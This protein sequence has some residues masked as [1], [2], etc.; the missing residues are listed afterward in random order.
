[1]NNDILASAPSNCTGSVPVDAVQLPSAEPT[2][3]QLEQQLRS[4][5]NNLNEAAWDEQCLAALEYWFTPSLRSSTEQQHQTLWDQYFDALAVTVGSRAAL[6][7][8]EDCLRF[9]LIE[10]I[11]ER[12]KCSAS[13]DQPQKQKRQL[14]KRGKDRQQRSTNPKAWINDIA[15]IGFKGVQLQIALHIIGLC[16]KA[17]DQ[18]KGGCGI[19]RKRV[20]ERYQRSLRTVEV[21]IQKAAGCRCHHCGTG[22]AS[23]EAEIRRAIR[24][25]RQNQPHRGLPK[26]HLATAAAGRLN[27][28]F[29]TENCGKSCGSNHFCEK[30]SDP[31]DQLEDNQSQERSTAENTPKAAVPLDLSSS[32]GGRRKIFY[33]RSSLGG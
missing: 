24:P 20:Q 15:Q 18:G 5:L 22:K 30:I 7:L 9:E 12:K 26:R 8:G 32:Y 14:G 3:E 6:Y 16:R 25:V 19:N 11:G 31:S 23:A 4:T 13:T 2:A 27:R 21:V 33:Q 1:M 29:S 17:H 28:S 10:R